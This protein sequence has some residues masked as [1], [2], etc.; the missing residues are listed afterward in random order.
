MCIR[1]STHPKSL[2][3]GYLPSRGDRVWC[4][5]HPILRFITRVCQMESHSDHSLRSVDLGYRICVKCAIETRDNF[6][7]S[8]RFVSILCQIRFVELI[9][10]PISDQNLCWYYEPRYTQCCCAD[11]RLSIGASI[12][13]HMWES[14]Q[15]HRRAGACAG[16]NWEEVRVWLGDRDLKRVEEWDLWGPAAGASTSF[17]WS[18][19]AGECARGSVIESDWENVRGEVSWFDLWEMLE[20]CCGWKVP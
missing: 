3:T 4:F 6:V 12:H 9:R 20:I 13:G 18:R 1:D 10:Y 8:R 14:V 17:C 15:V 16:W 19:M 11:M 5:S 7:Y 2:I